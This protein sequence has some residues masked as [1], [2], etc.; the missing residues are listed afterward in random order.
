MKYI[1]T[2]PTLVILSGGLDSTVLAYHMK[3]RQQLA[4]CVS[5]DY[6]QRHRRELMCA[7]LTCTRLGVPHYRL[8]LSNLRNALGSSA[9]TSDQPVPEGH[10]AEESMKAT[11]VPNRNMILMALAAGVAIANNAKAIAYGAH[12]GDHAIYPDCRPEFALAME[13]AIGL[14]DYQPPAVLR[15][16]IEITK[17]DIVRLGSRLHVHFEETHTC[18]NGDAIACGKCGTCV[19]RLEAFSEARVED[20][21]QYTDR[22]Y[23]MT[24]PKP[25]TA[26]QGNF[27]IAQH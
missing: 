9:L 21:L 10:Y 26:T 2:K 22:K 19:E 27:P 11:V 16:F 6:G 1:G 25:P 13:N 7:A 5:V 15:P 18:Y 12:A 17:A 20:P 23:W 3:D 8:D 4:G 14:C 24:V